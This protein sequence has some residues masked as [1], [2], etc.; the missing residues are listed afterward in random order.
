MKA[1]VHEQ[2]SGIDGLQIKDVHSLKMKE[3][4]ENRIAFSEKH[5]IKPLID[6]IYPFEDYKKA[7]ERLTE[8][9]QTGKIVLKI[10]D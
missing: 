5:L 10:A 1:L 2:K 8:A 6:T 3:E 7:F 9:K 4:L